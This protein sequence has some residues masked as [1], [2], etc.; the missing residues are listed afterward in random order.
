MTNRDDSA[1]NQEVEKD[2]R[3]RVWAEDERTEEPKEG[4]E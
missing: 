4:A 1:V 3:R 2:D